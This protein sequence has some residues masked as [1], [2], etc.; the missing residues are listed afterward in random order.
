MANGTREVVLLAWRPDEAE[1][2]RPL[3][4]GWRDASGHTRCCKL[5]CCPEGAACGRS[6]DPDASRRN[7][8]AAFH[9]AQSRWVLGALETPPVSVDTAC[10]LRE[11]GVESA[12]FVDTVRCVWSQ[13][14]LKVLY[15]SCAAPAKL[16]AAEIEYLFPAGDSPSRL[17][18]AAGF[19]ACEG[20]TSRVAACDVL[21]F[22]PATAEGIRRAVLAG[23][24]LPSSPSH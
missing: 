10:A 5:I 16:S 11:M 15:A 8:P 7:S 17:M 3:P 24:V 22:E 13:L 23:E 2:F 21:L 20:K 12:T 19:A 9:A 18:T 6:G 14:L 4:P 1:V